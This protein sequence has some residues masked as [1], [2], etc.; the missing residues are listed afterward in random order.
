MGLMTLLPLPPYLTFC[1]EYASPGGCGAF[2]V[3]ALAL[4]CA[5]PLSVHFVKYIQVMMLRVWPCLRSACKFYHER[6]RVSNEARGDF[7]HC[8]CPAPVHCSSTITDWD[9]GEL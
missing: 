1:W 6:L 3:Q 9:A 4:R 7:I 8:F 5:L 2:K